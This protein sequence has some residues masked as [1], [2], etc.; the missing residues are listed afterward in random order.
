MPPFIDSYTG[1]EEKR[2]SILV[3]TLLDPV[4]PS[5]RLVVGL[6]GKAAISTLAVSLAVSRADFL[7]V[8]ESLAVA[9]ASG[10][11]P[12]FAAFLLIMALGGLRWW[13]ALR[14]IGER[15]RL[16]HAIAL[17]SAAAMAGQVMPSVAGDGVRIWLAA[18]DGCSV[19]SAIHGVLLERVFMVLALFALALVTAPLFAA[20][21]AMLEFG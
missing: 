8:R 13:L 2:G 5:T 10:L 19:R 14:G 3:K 1:E 7:G 21:R 20:R 11:A 15:A 12:A 4:R 17:F 16:S 9:P 6:I 18:R